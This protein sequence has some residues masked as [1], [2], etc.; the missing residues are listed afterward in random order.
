M[1][2]PGPTPAP[3]RTPRP[4]LDVD[5]II[6]VATVRAMPPTL[7]AANIQFHSE[8]CVEHY[9]ALLV[10]HPGDSLYP[11]DALGIAES[12]LKTRAECANDGFHP[13]IDLE[14]AC[15]GYLVGGVPLPPTLT[16][17]SQIAGNLR[18]GGTARD[19]RGNMLVHFRRLPDQAAPGCWYY[20]AN[21]RTWSWT[22]VNVG[23][24]LYRPD[25]SR[26][27]AKLRGLLVSS[28]SNLERVAQIADLVELVRTED[29]LCG[30]QGWYPYP[31]VA[32]VSE[33]GESSSTGWRDEGVLVLNWQEN[34]RPYDQRACWL[35]DPDL[36]EKGWTA[37]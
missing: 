27:D 20:S 16:V 31:A 33:C 14:I 1:D 18:A 24:G 30:V 15:K 19:S 34:H 36:G 25:H 11:E 2:F 17:G 4:T 7:V 26:C 9:Q 8:S 22:A 35:F 12:L 23:A 29:E 37:P 28:A 32:S 10:D 3:T 13:E 5:Q 21:S 6:A